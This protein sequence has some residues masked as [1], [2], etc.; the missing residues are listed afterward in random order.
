MLFSNVPTTFS[1]KK[2]DFRTV[3]REPG[4]DINAHPMHFLMETVSLH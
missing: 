1:V 3:T 2:S 4:L